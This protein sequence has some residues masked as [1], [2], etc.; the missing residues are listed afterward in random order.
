MIW[1]MTLALTQ[2]TQ[3]VCTRRDYVNP[4]P[5]EIERSETDVLD[6]ADSEPAH[7]LN[8]G[9]VRFSSMPAL[10]GDAYVAEF[11]PD[12]HGGARVSFTWLIGHWRTR[13]VKERQW[14]FDIPPTRFRELKAATVDAMTWVRP[15]RPG[16]AE[17]EMILCMDG[18]GFLTET[19]RNGEVQSLSG[20]CPYVMD[21]DHPN[22]AVEAVVLS[23]VCP[24]FSQEF[25]PRDGLGAACIRRDRRIRSA[26][27]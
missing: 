10:G 22:R 15:N 14:T 23:I 20:S 4:R 25:N 21:E 6:A 18:P 5:C 9:S 24:R 26:R 12:R 16:G 13:W 1:L 17:G 2:A 27:R 11:R 19:V 8:E 7:S 3:S